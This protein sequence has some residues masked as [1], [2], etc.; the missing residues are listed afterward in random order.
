MW[1]LEAGEY[2]MPQK[3][4]ERIE[5]GREGDLKESCTIV[6]VYKIGGFDRGGEVEGERPRCQWEK[7]L[8]CVECCFHGHERGSMQ[9][10][11]FIDYHS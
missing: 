6:F 11:I 8:S 1:Y 9:C 3:F 10:N 4:E 5:G 2:V 7:S